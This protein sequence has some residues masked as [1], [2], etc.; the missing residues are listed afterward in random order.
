MKVGRKLATKL[1]NASKF[2]LGF[3]MPAAGAAA[4]HP[5]D[6]AMLARIA[7]TARE[8]TSAFDEFDYARAL[9]RTESAF[10]WFCDDYVELVKGR[11][12][13]SQGDE[14]AS[15]AL[16]A[17]RIALSALQRLFAPFMPFT[18]E[19][20]WRWWNE[21]SIHLQSWPNADELASVAGTQTAPSEALLAVSSD[22]LGQIRRAKTEAKTSQK[23][24]VALARLHCDARTRQLFEA[25]R[26]DVTEAGSVLDW[27]IVEES[28]GAVVHVDVELAPTA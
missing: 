3:P 20:V 18:A 27:D 16:A 22:V 12:Y 9:E 7:E 24:A 17:M 19:T 28:A 21:G 6:L 1:L 10:W 15:S 13:G 8:A 26:S 25:V 2:V 4:T 14:A 23:T 5:I 11:A